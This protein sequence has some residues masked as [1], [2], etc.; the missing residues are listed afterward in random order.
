MEFNDT[1]KVILGEGATLPFR[2][3]DTDT[4][5]DLRAKGYVDDE[6]NNIWFEDDLQEYKLN[7]GDRILVKTGLRIQHGLILEE[8]IN[9]YIAGDVQI[10]PRSGLSL[11]G[12]DISLGTIDIDYT[13]D[14]GV[15]VANN[16]DEEF[17]ISNNDRIA[18]L[19]IGMCLIPKQGAYKRVN[20]F[21]DTNRGEGGFGH[22]G[23]K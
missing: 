16:S 8:D 1:I 23:K 4:G 20:D 15:I 12:I 11:K 10:R 22:T 17:T 19:V 6:G 13:G 21:D 5:G 18:Q 9:Y 7:P 3:H 14:L 2:K